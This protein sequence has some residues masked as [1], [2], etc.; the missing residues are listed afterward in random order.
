MQVPKGDAKAA[1]PASRRRDTRRRV[2]AGIAIL[3]A[4]YAAIAFV[5]LEPNATYSVDSV[6]KFVQARTLLA[7]KFLSAG[8]VNRGAYIDPDGVFFPFT[9]PYVFRTP[10]GWQSIFPTASALLLAPF[11]PWGLAGLTV[12]ALLGALLLLWTTWRFGASTPAS[13]AL[14]W[15]LGTATILWFYATS[16]NEHGLAA[17]LTTAALVAALEARERGVVAAGL[18]LGLAGVFRD[19]A[20]LVGPGLVVAR[21]LGGT[22]APGALIREAAFMGAGALVP[23]AAMAALDVYAYHRPMSAH[24]LHA[25]APL[26]R[27]LPDHAVSH[28]PA[29]PVIPWSDRPD[30]LVRQWLLGLGTFLEEGLAA[31]ALAGAVVLRRRTGSALGLVAVLGVLAAARVVDVWALVSLPKFVGGLYRLCPFVVFA[32]VPLPAGATSSPAR[33]AAIWT[34]VLY[35]AFAIVGLNTVGGKSFGPRL[36][37]PLLPLLTVSAVESIAS[38]TA[39]MRAARVDGLVGAIGILMILASVTMQFGVALPAWAMRNALDARA[40][41][42]VAETMDTIVVIDHPSAVQLTG[43]FYFDRVVFLATSGSEGERM[44]AR[45]AAARVTTFTVLSRFERPPVAFSP[46]GLE[47]EARD[48]RLVSQRWRR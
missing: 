7:N 16:P 47:S 22:R 38:W 32:F 35:L 23:L 14:P 42:R 15:V 24:L 44:G 2:L 10:T 13:W 19:E 5:V 17:A 25:V 6:V 46:Y 28:L 27:W 11:S 36:L 26:Q 29:L 12:P 48:G 37:F 8:F 30:V 41:A 20:L 45:L 31:A 9:S 21:H 18:L 33:R 39:R 40:I 43:P 34:T 4:F 1:G 3:G